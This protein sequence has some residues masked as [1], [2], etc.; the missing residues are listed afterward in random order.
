MPTR[1]TEDDRT[2]VLEVF[3]AV[4]PG[5]DEKSE[6]DRRFLEALLYLTV[7]NLGRRAR[8]KEFGNWNTVWKRFWRLSASGT[9]ERLFLA[10]A[11]TGRT[12]DFVQVFDST[13]IRARV[14]AA[15]AKRGRKIRRSAVR[16]A[17]PARRSISSAMRRPAARFPPDGQRG[18][19][20]KAVRD[21]AGDRP[22]RRARGGHRRQELRLR[23]EPAGRARPRH[24]AGRSAPQERE[25]CQARTQRPV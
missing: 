6:H 15:G 25:G 23:G 5:R 1:L 9:F 3:R 19:R 10:L 13:S 16:A 17:G 8:P 7:T 24:R 4:L 12:A 21:L 22:R 20:H 14:S 2:L 11:E 18:E